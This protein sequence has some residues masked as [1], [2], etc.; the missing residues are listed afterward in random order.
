MRKVTIV[1]CCECN[2]YYDNQYELLKIILHKICLWFQSNVRYDTTAVIL[3][4]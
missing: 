4:P 1:T 2:A 3:W